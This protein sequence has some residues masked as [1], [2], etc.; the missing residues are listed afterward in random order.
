MAGRVLAQI[1]I[2]GTQVV[3]RAFVDAYRQAAANAGRGGAAAACAA[4][5]GAGQAAKRGGEIVHNGMSVGE[6]R[7]ILNVPDTAT[8]DQINK[9]FEHLFKV[10]EKNEGGS[11]YL[12]SKVIRAKEALEVEAKLMEQEKEGSKEGEKK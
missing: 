2:Y 4:S 7:Q 12:Q 5:G 3:S 10:N 8:M 11:F 1:I 9:H 6:A